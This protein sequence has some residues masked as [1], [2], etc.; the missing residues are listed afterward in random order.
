MNVKEF[1][2]KV[3][4]PYGEIIYEKVKR[5]FIEEK[6]K[7]YFEGKIRELNIKYWEVIRKGL[8][9]KGRG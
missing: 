6:F 7:Q 9:K 8:M 3:V 5:E 4:I 2:E 1:N